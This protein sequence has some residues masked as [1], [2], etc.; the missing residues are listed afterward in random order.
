MESQLEQYKVSHI[1]SRGQE[2][3][4][5]AIQTASKIEVVAVR[6]GK[7]HILL[8]LE[9]FW[10]PQRL[11]SKIYRIFYFAHCLATT[12]VSRCIMIVVNLYSP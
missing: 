7:I 10:Q 9:A 11:V 12:S 8:I 5:M 2:K 1:W 6:R 3:G 4:S